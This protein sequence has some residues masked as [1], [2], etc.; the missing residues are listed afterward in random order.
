VKPTLAVDLAGVHLPTPVMIASGFLSSPKELAGLVDP[1]KVGGIVTRTITAEPN[2]GAPTPRM[3]ETASGLLA[4]TGLQNEGV[5]AFVADLPALTQV[6]VPLFASIGGT[7]VEEVTRVAARLIA[8]RAVGALELN[9]SCPDAHREDRPFAASANRAAEVVAAVAGISRV[10]VFAKL[11]DE[12][13]DVVEVATQCVAAGA[14]GLTL[15][16]PIRGLAIDAETSR[17]K[18]ASGAGRLSGPAIK[19]VALLAVYRV[20]EALPDTPI[21]GVGGI[22]TADDA[23]EFLLAGA[24]AVQIGTAM[25]TNPSAPVDVAVGVGRYLVEHELSSPAALRGRAHQ[26]MAGDRR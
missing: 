13:A 7:T 22:A 1:R 20:A 17:P 25:F 21:I 9:L 10:A 18:L 14:H 12:G 6:G 24:W 15:I 16:N 26:Q 2:L 5:E 11:S 23:V 3:A 19:P 4:E 8:L